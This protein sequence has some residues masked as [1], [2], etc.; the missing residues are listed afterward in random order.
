MEMADSETE[1]DGSPVETPEQVEKEGMVEYL[2]STGRIRRALAGS[3]SDQGL[4]NWT[5]LIEGDEDYFM[6]FKGVGKKTAEAF[7]ELC[8]M[9]KEMMK[10]SENAPGI[11]EILGSVPRI[12][13]PVIDTFLEGG[14]ADLSKFKGVTKEEL[15]VFKGVG[16]KLSESILEVTSEAIEKYGLPEVIEDA[17]AEI[18]T[19]GKE[20]VEEEG[21]PLR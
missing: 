5:S 20:E 15:M 4:D 8:S 6:S 14:F 18:P 16:P 2:T 11:V 3:V 19:E 12:T 7:M 21:S 17:T 10:K 9:R 1:N 13:Q